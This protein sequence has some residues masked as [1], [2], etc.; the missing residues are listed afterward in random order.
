MACHG[1]LVLR[2]FQPGKGPQIPDSRRT[3]RLKHE[4]VTNQQTGRNC[5]NSNVRSRI[6]A[7]RLSFTLQQTGVSNTSIPG[8]LPTAF[9]IDHSNNFDIEGKRSACQTRPFCQYFQYQWIVQ[10]DQ[11]AFE[12]FDVCTFLTCSIE[13]SSF[14]G[15]CLNYTIMSFCPRPSNP[16]FTVNIYELQICHGV[17]YTH[18]T[19]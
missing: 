9:S 19:H 6:L 12:N 1:M 11:S 7:I 13:T 8:F 18:K 10:E 17:D 3:K 4:V 16:L 15:S 2:L 5:S 14:K